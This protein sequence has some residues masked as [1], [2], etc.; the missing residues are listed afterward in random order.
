MN[1]MNKITREWLRGG[2][3]RW[4]EIATAKCDIECLIGKSVD[5]VMIKGLEIEYISVFGYCSFKIRFV[6]LRSK[7]P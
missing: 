4:K 2:G 7:N 5:E 3:D 6:L 1:C